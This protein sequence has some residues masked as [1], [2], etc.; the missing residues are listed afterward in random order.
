MIRVAPEATLKS[1]VSG[2]GRGQI[3]DVGCLIDLH[4]GTVCSGGLQRQVSSPGDFILVRVI[5]MYCGDGDG[6]IRID[7]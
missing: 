2:D 3:E 5:E 6:R 7:R 1:C 4:R